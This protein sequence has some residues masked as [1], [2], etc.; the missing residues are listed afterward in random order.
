MNHT[1]NKINLHAVIPIDFAGLRFDQALAKLFPDYSRARLQDWL[2]SGKILING[3]IL[4]GKNKVQGGE[5]VSV[6]ANLDIENTWSAEEIQ[7]NILY[8]D[9]ALLV[10]NKPVGM[11]VHPGAGNRSGTLLNALLHHCPILATVPRAGIVHRLDKDTSGVLVIAKTLPVHHAL[12]SQLQKRKIEREYRAIVCGVMTGGGT[13]DEPIG[14]HPKHR[15]KMAVIDTGK[16]AVTHY[17]VIERFRKH[18][19]IKLLLETG[20]THQIRVHMAYIHYPILGD[21]QYNPRLAIPK[22]AGMV[23]SQAL[24]SFKRQAL[25]A[26]RLTLKHPLTAELMSFEAPLPQDLLNMLELLK[27]DNQEEE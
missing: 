11:V 3:Q 23:F 18:T 13:V 6:D 12:V 8:E 14:R 21:V 27:N 17:R 22:N 26:F 1:T 24:K 16:P 2:K 7:L 4:P 19:Y 20:R 9:G 15:T 10:I 25:H 5:S